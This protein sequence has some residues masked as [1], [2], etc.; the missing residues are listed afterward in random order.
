MEIPKA[1]GSV[2]RGD[3]ARFCRPACARGPLATSDA[4]KV[5]GLYEV[6]GGQEVGYASYRS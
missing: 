6:P 5:T 2:A 1:M 4:E 3:Y